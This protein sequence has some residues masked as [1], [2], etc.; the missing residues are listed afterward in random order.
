MNGFYTNNTRLV[1][2]AG[3]LIQIIQ[4]YRSN[5]YYIILHHRYEIIV[6]DYEED[7]FDPSLKQSRVQKDFA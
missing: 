7:F 3:V 5:I 2:R 4:I 6:N 1:I